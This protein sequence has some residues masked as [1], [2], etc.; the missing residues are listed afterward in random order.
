MC[1]NLL[2]SSEGWS[3]RV[4]SLDTAA[5]VQYVQHTGVHRQEEEED[6]D[7]AR[8]LGD[9][10]NGF[11]AELMAGVKRPRVGVG[12]ECLINLPHFATQ[13]YRKSSK[14]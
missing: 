4:G 9:N 6:G 11:R 5:V 2:G 3:L 12:S 8:Q 10:D 7:R 1:K 14:R 13:Q